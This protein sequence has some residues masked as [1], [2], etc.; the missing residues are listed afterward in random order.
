MVHQC[1]QAVKSVPKARMDRPVRIKTGR[2]GRIDEDI[3]LLEQTLEITKILRYTRY[4]KDEAPLVKRT[5]EETR[6]SFCF[7]L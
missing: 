3:V 1:L 5:E 7:H 6:N 4:T 2:C